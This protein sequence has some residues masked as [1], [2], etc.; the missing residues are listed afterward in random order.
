MPDNAPGDSG[1]SVDNRRLFSSPPETSSRSSAALK[2]D[3]ALGA[4]SEGEVESEV[5]DPPRLTST[6][7][8]ECSGGETRTLNL[9]GALDE[10][11]EQHQLE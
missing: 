11:P 7:D 4:R 1:S 10:D 8:E 6:N 2:E 3:G 9:A 5:P